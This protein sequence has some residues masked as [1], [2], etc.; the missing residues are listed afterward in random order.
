MITQAKTVSASEIQARPSVA[1]QCDQQK[2]VASVVATKTDK[3]KR[4]HTVMIK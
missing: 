2:D 1:G 3:L 4:A